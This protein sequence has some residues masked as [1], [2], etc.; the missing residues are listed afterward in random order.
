MT[1]SRTEEKIEWFEPNH[2]ILLSYHFV[3]KGMAWEWV[4]LQLHNNST[5]KIHTARI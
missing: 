3:R 1:R 4:I 2:H 5:G